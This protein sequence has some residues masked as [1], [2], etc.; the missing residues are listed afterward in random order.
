M[1]CSDCLVKCDEISKLCPV[2][3]TKRID[4]VIESQPKIVPPNNNLEDESNVK[5]KECIINIKWHNGICECSCKNNEINDSY[6]QNQNNENEDCDLYYIC[7]L[8]FL[9]G[10]LIVMGITITWLGAII[11]LVICHGNCHSNSE[12]RCYI[13]S[14]LTGITLTI[15]IALLFVSYKTVNEFKRF[16][17]GLFGA[18]ILVLTLSFTYNNSINPYVFFLLIPFI[19]MCI[20]CST[21]SIG[22][23][24]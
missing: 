21:R 2:C 16:L 1:I 10:K 23:S 20:Y 13:S 3:R 7:H 9:I 17:I 14:L 15:I 12:I 8:I 24:D 5:S 4:I 19:P 11:P 18:V 22:G 6:H